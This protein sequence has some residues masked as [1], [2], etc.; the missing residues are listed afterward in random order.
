MV[1]MLIER[2]ELP[3][4]GE[5]VAGKKLPAACS[6]D[7]EVGIGGVGIHR[8]GLF[9]QLLGLVITRELLFGRI[10]ALGCTEITHRDIERILS[11]R[12]MRRRDRR[13]VGGDHEEGRN[14]RRGA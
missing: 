6:E 3:D 9:G 11:S 14:D 12:S 5:R 13:G 1:E 2:A 4:I 8:D 7:Q 10:E